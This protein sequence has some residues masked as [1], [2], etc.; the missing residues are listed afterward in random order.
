[1]PGGPSPPPRPAGDPHGL[2]LA[3]IRAG[4]TDAR[5]TPGHSCALAVQLSWQCSRLRARASP[6]ERGHCEDRT[7]RPIDRRRWAARFLA[8]SGG[9]HGRSRRGLWEREVVEGGMLG[10][11]PFWRPNTFTWRWFA[12]ARAL[13]RRMPSGLIPNLSTKRHGSYLCARP[14]SQLIPMESCRPRSKAFL[15]S[16]CHHLPGRAGRLCSIVSS[17][18]ACLERAPGVH[19]QSAGPERAPGVVCM[20]PKGARP[21][22]CRSRRWPPGGPRRGVPSELDIVVEWAN[23]LPSASADRSASQGL[24]RSIERSRRAR[25]GPAVSAG[26]HSGRFGSLVSHVGRAMRRRCTCARSDLGRRR[27]PWRALRLRPR[28]ATRP[29]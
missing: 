3:H 18:S 28:S 20:C 6:R 15:P 22:L 19:A 8:R 23:A 13:R 2:G 1:M 21:V 16:M 12:G 24:S 9:R 25:R 11:K 29:S 27:C 5:S 7:G 4:G 26:L 14:L 17:G 10:E